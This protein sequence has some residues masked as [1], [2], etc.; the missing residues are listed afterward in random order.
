MSTNRIYIAALLLAAL[1]TPLQAQINNPA[2][3]ENLVFD[4]ARL[5]KAERD[6]FLFQ[7][8]EDDERS[9]WKY[10]SNGERFDASANNI[11]GQEGGYSLKLKP[12]E[13][14]C[15][16][17]FDTTYHKEIRIALNFAGCS[18]PKDSYIK[19]TGYKNNAPYANETKK[20]PSDDYTFPYHTIVG[21]NG[22]I[23][24]SSTQIGYTQSLTL[25]AFAK[26]NDNY[27]CLDSLYVHGDIPS[28]S[29]FT[30]K[31]NWRDTADWSHLPAERHRKALIK[32]DITVD[33]DIKCKEALI[34]EGSIHIGQGNRLQVSNLSFFDTGAFLTSEG[35]IQVD[36]CIKV[37][38]TFKKKGEWYHI[39]FPFDVYAEGID[40]A[41][42]IKDGTPNAGGNFLYIL[43]YNGDRRQTSN[44][45]SGNWDVL[46]PAAGSPVFEK[47]KGYLVAIDALATL[48]T[49]TFSSK[50]KIPEG[51]GRE[52]ALAIRAAASST[53]N[54][55]AGWYLCGN[56]F[57]AP[58][59]LRQI[60]KSADLDG[61]IY[62]YDGSTYKA[63]PIGSNHQLPPFSAFFVKAK[64]NTDLQLT[65][66][67]GNGKDILISCSS[68]LRLA[69]E[70]A[71]GNPTSTI[72][73]TPAA[74]TIRGNILTTNNLQFPANLSVYNQSGQL[75]LRQGIPSGTSTTPLPLA[76]GFYI[77][78]IESPTYRTQHKC[79]IN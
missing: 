73:I 54:E 55:N 76:T 52:G 21:K 66:V 29:L 34:S 31:G 32:G 65:K 42:Q 71:T 12:G 7:F 35:N 20:V 28:Y 5:N 9:N 19:I 58:L 23:F 77:L 38:R 70:P 75:V 59:S 17:N 39:S 50:G 53:D 44:S 41:F 11:K 2:A 49:I 4:T 8:F 57:P 33:R 18:L 45:P 56:P 27:F 10:E 47:D 15:F 24:K 46:T 6:T 48:D 78:K 3:W 36:G 68:P 22:A 60:P 40:P 16:E 63:Y 61:Y 67:D 30:G 69:V 74:S 79:I 51:F 13:N 1:L 64:T 37:Q 62:V 72:N 43:S 14:I 25:T 26:G